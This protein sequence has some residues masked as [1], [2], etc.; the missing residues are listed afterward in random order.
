MGLS[1][2]V[3]L[4]S[5]KKMDLYPY[6]AIERS[7][8]FKTVKDASYWDTGIHAFIK[9]RFYGLYTYSQDVQADQLNATKDYGNRNG[10]PHRMNDSF[11]ADDYTL[12]DVWIGYYNGINNANVAIAGYNALTA[13]T[14]A[15]TDSLKKYLGGA[16][17]ARAYYYQNLLL[18]YAKT[19]N[20]STASTDA[21]VP[22]QLVY[23]PSAKPARASIQA[24]YDQIIL[25]INEAKSK[26]AAVPGRVG[27]SR[28]T[29]DAAVALEARV[30]LYKKDYAGAYTAAASLV[31]G[32]KYTLYNTSANVKNYWHTDLRGEDIMQLHGSIAN[33]F[34]VNNTYLNYDAGGSTFKPDFIPTKAVID[35][36]EDS[37]LRKNVYFELKH[38]TISSVV[39]NN[40]IKVV[41]KFPGNPALFAGAVTNYQHFPKL[42]RI[43]EQYLIA[44][45]AAY[46]NNGDETNSRKYLNALRAA[47]GLT[48]TSATGTALLEEIKKERQRE[49]AFE[50][51]RLFDLK[52]WGLGVVRGAVQDLTLLTSAPAADFHELN[53]PAN[54]DKIV[55]G[56]PTNDIIINPNIRPNNP[57]W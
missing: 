47:R 11:N 36:Y 37:D 35:L 40:T 28:F 38:I 50:G 56:I 21:G 8:S 31:D 13:T 52:R 30:K 42:F 41:N 45:E 39:Y 6:N 53:K 43:A 16:H 32:A 44:S 2:A 20:A 46:F 14:A 48:A 3:V 1:V 15:E 24:V 25:D 5:C 19:Y 17:L 4:G 12:R 49:L 10:A 27:A 26:L 7:Q 57:G 22:L 29:L 23:D 34:N 18:R 54:F 55:W 33:N 9:G 51:F